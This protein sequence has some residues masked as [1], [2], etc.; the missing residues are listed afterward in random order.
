MFRPG[1]GAGVLEIQFELE[2]EVADAMG[3]CLSG[4]IKKMH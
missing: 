2:F 4:M 1:V 3:G